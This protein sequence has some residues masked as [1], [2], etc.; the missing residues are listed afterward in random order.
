MP[1]TKQD[2]QNLYNLSGDEV[3]QTLTVA[4]LSDEQESQG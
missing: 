2:L 3:S 1:Y 4:G